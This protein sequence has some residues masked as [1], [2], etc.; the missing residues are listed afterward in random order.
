LI[1]NLAQKDEPIKLTVRRGSGEVEMDIKAAE[2]RQRGTWEE[3]Q[4]SNLHSPVSIPGLGVA[5]RVKPVLRG[6]EAGKPAD[7]KMQAGD[8]IKA[9]TYA[10]DLA[11]EKRETV[12]IGEPQWSTIFAVYL[13]A[14]AKSEA[15][16]LKV[17]DKDGNERMV[18]LSSVKDETWPYPDRGLRRE[19][20]AVTVRAKDIVAAVGL[21]LNDTRRKIGQLYLGL[22]S[23]ARGYVDAKDSVTGPLGL[24]EV[25]YRMAESGWTELIFIIGFIS[26]NLAVVNFLPI[27]ILDGGHMVFLII[28]KL[29]G[30]PASERVLIIAN[31][32][33]L[34][35]ILSLMLTV[36]LLDFRKFG[37][38]DFLG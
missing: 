18:Q 7:G 38:L 17:V 1:W 23:M 19:P 31:V 29:R 22:N 24:L 27:P 34:V 25:T 30:K 4:P 37:W 26:I 3:Q 14:A 36:I 28:E 15:I 10:T 20:A 35:L 2:I 21:G 6:V 33:G 12:E 16:E 8:T 32:V 9:V 13:Q 5:Y 11:G